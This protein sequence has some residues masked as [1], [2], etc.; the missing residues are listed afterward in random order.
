MRQTQRF[1]ELKHVTDR[2]DNKGWLVDI[3]MNV[4]GWRDLSAGR[5]ASEDAAHAQWWAQV[6]RRSLKGGVYIDDE[7]KQKV[8]P[9]FSL[10]SS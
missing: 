6:R 10:T 2:H 5:S 3:V 1:D 7:S 9:D 4:S 8:L